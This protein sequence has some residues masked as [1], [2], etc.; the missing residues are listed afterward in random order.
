MNLNSSDASCAAV[1]GDPENR[2]NGFS[3]LI[4]VIGTSA[5]FENAVCVVSMEAAELTNELAH[6]NLLLQSKACL[7][8]NSRLLPPF[9]SQS[10]LA[11]VF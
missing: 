2:E 10:C 1:K 11:L 3:V 5:A 4:L 8:R 7:E 9:G 6:D